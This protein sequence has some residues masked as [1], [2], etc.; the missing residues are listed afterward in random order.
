ME[1]KIIKD[2]ALEVHNC[3]TTAYMN[4][5]DHRMKSVVYRVSTHLILLLFSEILSV[6]VVT[7]VSLQAFL[8]SACM[9]IHHLSMS[10]LEVDWYYLPTVTAP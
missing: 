1:Q 3:I 10:L 9:S 6:S 7:G 5:V 2:C 4:L 8:T